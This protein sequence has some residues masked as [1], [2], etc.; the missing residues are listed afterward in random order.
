M[1][2]QH[3]SLIRLHSPLVRLHLSLTR[4]HSSLTRLHS[5]TL[6]SHSSALVSSLVYNISNNHQKAVILH[7]FSSLRQV[8]DNEN[9]QCDFYSSNDKTLEETR[10]SIMKCSES[11]CFRKLKPGIVLF[12]L[13][14]PPAILDSLQISPNLPSLQLGYL[15]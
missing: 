5:S 3:S 13:L 10:L 7:L 9:S 2:K 6:A 12:K 1:I 4:L 11:Y 8:Y 15:L 14:P